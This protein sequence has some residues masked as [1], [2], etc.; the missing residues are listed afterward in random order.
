MTVWKESNETMRSPKKKKGK[1]KEVNTGIQMDQQ[2]TKQG[3]WKDKTRKKKRGKRPI[4]TKASI[5]ETSTTRRRRRRPG[6]RYEYDDDEKNQ[7]V[8]RI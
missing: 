1:R 3:I 4:T 5:I 2:Q 7:S 6:R 8:W